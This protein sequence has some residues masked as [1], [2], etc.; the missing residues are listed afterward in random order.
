MAGLL[1]L[2]YETVTVLT[3][4]EHTSV[5]HTPEPDSEAAERPALPGGWKAAAGTTGT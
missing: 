3:D 1:T 5:V 4:P 2:P